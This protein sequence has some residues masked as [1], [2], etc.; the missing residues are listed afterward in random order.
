MAGCCGPRSLLISGRASPII[1]TKKAEVPL[2]SQVK[3]TLGWICQSKATQGDFMESGPRRLAFRRLWPGAICCALY[4]VLAMTTYGFVSLR[5]P[6]VGFSISMDS[7]E[8]IWWLAWAAHALPHVHD[9]FLADGQNVPYG[10]NFGAQGSMLALGVLF[11]PVTKLFGPIVTWNILLRLSIAASA[12]SMCFVLRRWTSWWPAAFFGGLLYAFCGYMSWLNLY[13]FLIFVPLPPLIFLY[14]HEILVRQR[15]RSWLTGLGLGVLCAAQFFISTEVLAGTVV[16]ASIATAL[17]VVIDFHSL[18]VRWRYAFNALVYAAGVGFILLAYPLWFTF[19][20]PQHINGPPETVAYWA[21]F[22]PVDLFS[23][24][25]NGTNWGTTTKG[26]LAFGHVVYLGW[27][28]VVV[29]TAF[30]IAFRRRR[31][32][33]FAGVMALISFVLSLGPRLWVNGHETSVPLPALVFEHLPALDGFQLGR[34]AIF[35][36]MFAAGMFAIGIEELWRRLQRSRGP[37]TVPRHWRV[38][39]ASLVVG[40][41]VLI[42]AVPLAPRKSPGS[43]PVSTPAFFSSSAAS[44]IPPGSVVLAYPYPHFTLATALAPIPN[45]MLYQA[46]S[47]MRFRLLGGYGYFPSPTGQGGTTSPASLEPSSVQTLFDTTFAGVATPARQKVLSGRNPAED[48]RAFLRR[49]DV[50]T[51]IVI[52]TPSVLRLGSIVTHIGNPA[53]AIHVISSA[54]GPPV[55]TGGVTAWF[56][57]KQRLVA[58]ASEPSSKPE[59]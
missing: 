39:T 42:V 9:M 37:A 13:P 33:L 55:R 57:V 22:A 48:I 12:A 52:D 7:V 34:F 43:I 29:L 17:L 45:A 35:T 40:V 28:L 47:G 46:I 1:W 26:S 20:G 5:T 30:A 21:A 3:S 16:M 10:Q 54:I 23:L 49:Y 31:A 8:Q 18:A 6:T 53:P 11:A 32:L 59:S 4:V 41:V 14:L 44:E 27:P 25:V 15:W 24:F 58:T 50:G 36:A 2:V 38:A 19:A 51:V 56:H